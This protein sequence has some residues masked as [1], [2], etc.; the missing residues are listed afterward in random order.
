[1][2]GTV[3]VFIP[4]RADGERMTGEVPKGM[5]KRATFTRSVDVRT[6]LDPLATRNLSNA[7]PAPKPKP[8]NPK[9]A[10]KGWSL[11]PVVAVVEPVVEPTSVPTVEV[12]PEHAEHCG[13]TFRTPNGYAWHLTNMHPAVAA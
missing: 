9:V 13:K 5:R 3:N 7:I 1:M 6:F 2:T 12:R 10:P 8:F 11:R 4:I